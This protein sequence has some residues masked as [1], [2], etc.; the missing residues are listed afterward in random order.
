M[1]AIA[2]FGV[3]H[4]RLVL[5]AW[6]IVFAAAIAV[7]TQTREH[8]RQPSLAI[9]GSDS[10]RADKLT[11]KEFGGTVSMAILLEGPPKVVESRGPAVVR[12]LQKIEGVQ[13]LSPW[14]I[15]GARVLKE[16]GGQAM[17]ALQV[18]KPFQQISEET[19]PAV[20][21]VLDRQETGGL[22]AE[23]TGLAPLVRALNEASLD[24]LHKGELIALPV[25]FL[26]LLLVF[27]SPIAA[28]VPALSGLLVIRLGIALMGLVAEQS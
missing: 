3:K 23:I 10:D 13:V 11:R 19:V 7:G 24:S 28:L 8:I 2:R 4:R 25:L 1:S 12:E 27:R 22:S 16:P 14:A 18:R 9:P 20:Q 21:R 26:M 17:L 5:L 15:G 6:L